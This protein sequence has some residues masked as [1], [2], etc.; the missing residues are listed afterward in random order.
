MSEVLP[1]SMPKDRREIEEIQRRQKVKAVD[2]AKKSSF[3]K[4][5]LTGID[6]NKLDDPEEWQKIPLLEKDELRRLTA[7]DFYTDFCIASGSEIC[8]FWRSGGT[9]GKPLFYPKT[10]EDIRY[11]MVGFTRTFECSGTDAGHVAHNSFPLGIHPA[12][13]MWARAARILDIGTVW[14]GAGTSLPSATQ[15][16]LIRTLKPTLW[17]GMS[18][19]GL[20]LANLAQSEEFDLSSSTVNRILCTAEPVSQAKRNKLEREWGAE[21]F[22]CFGMTECSMMGAESDKRDG[23]HIWT[24]LAYIEVVDEETKRPV[25]EGEPGLLIVTPLFSNNGAPFLRWNAGDVVTYKSEGS[26]GSD[27][28]VFPV[29]EHAHRTAGFF[30]VR[31]INI[32]HQEFEDFLFENTAVMDF[33]AEALESEDGND[34][35]K[36]SIEARRAADVAALRIAVLDGTKDR[37]ELTPEVEFLAVGTLA[38]EFESSVKAPRFMDKRG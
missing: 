3:W 21:M 26:T 28:A 24:D 7:E 2:N 16:N 4:D 37:F 19:Y 31:G 9:T 8:E 33:K 13:H 29:I 22:D 34:V 23:F 1:L 38:N 17:M 35:F 11:N 14:A 27:F 30:K 5:R 15:L 20:H 10:Y 36:V 12:G 32:N 18:S 25:A 6:M